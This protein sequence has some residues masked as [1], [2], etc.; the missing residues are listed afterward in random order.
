GN[1][2]LKNLYII[3]FLFFFMVT[4]FFDGYCARKLNQ[5]SKLGKILDPL[6]D[7]TCIITISYL[8]M[9]YKA[10]PV[11]VFY[12]ILV[13]EFIVLLGS[14]ILI[15]K[16]NFIPVSNILG[17][18]GVFFI[19]LSMLG[20]LFLAIEKNL[21]PYTLLIIGLT[22]YLISFMIYFL[23]YLHVMEQIQKQIRKIYSYFQ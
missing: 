16:K 11:W 23:R 15:Q 19:S 2:N 6:A 18:A 20:Y 14:I 7:K 13:R 12:I 9:K 5:V 3:I 10:F 4:D 22:F 1:F 8:I 21:I 17:K